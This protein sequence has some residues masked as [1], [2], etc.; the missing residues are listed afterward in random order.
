MWPAHALGCRLLCKNLSRTHYHF[1]WEKLPHP[2]IATLVD[3]A[4]F[5]A[6]AKVIRHG[7]GHDRDWT[8]KK[9]IRRHHNWQALECAQKYGTE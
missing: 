1:S 2:P 5:S 4:R 9:K 6:A 8:N 3:R 7:L